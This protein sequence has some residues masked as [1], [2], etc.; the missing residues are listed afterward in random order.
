MD[1]AER[2]SLLSVSWAVGQAVD[3]IAWA[4]YRAPDASGTEDICARLEKC[5]SVLAEI[6]TEVKRRPGDDEEEKD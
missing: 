6:Q 2:E 1:H 5:S 3:E 4:L